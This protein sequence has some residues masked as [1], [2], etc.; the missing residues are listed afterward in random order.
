MLERWVETSVRGLPY[1]REQQVTREDEE[2]A[3]NPD[4]AEHS[5]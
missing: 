4:Q 2:E 5:T 1:N 3:A